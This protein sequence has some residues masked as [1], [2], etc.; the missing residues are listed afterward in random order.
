ML[1]IYVSDIPTS[2]SLKSWQKSFQEGVCVGGGGSNVS[3]QKMGC[4]HSIAFTFT[5][6]VSPHWKIV[7]M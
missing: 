6:S 1:W 3:H 2:N 5:V 7:P 4:G